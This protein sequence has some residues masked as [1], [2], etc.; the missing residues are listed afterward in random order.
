MTRIVLF[1]FILITFQS[2]LLAQMPGFTQ[3]D[4]NIGLPSNTV[5]DITQDE[6]GFIWMATD[7]GLSRFDGLSFKNFTIADGLP[8][9]EI[10]H[11]FQDSKKRIWLSGFNGKLGY[12]QKQKFY[13][14]E[15]S[16][17][18]NE[19]KFNIFISDIF[20]DSKNNI[21]FFESFN[22][23][24]KLDTNNQVSTYNFKNTPQLNNSKQYNIAEDIHGEI[25]ILKSITHKSNLSEF[26][27][28][29]ISK[30]NWENL[31][32]DSFDASV[33]IKLRTKKSEK[34]KNVDSV[35]MKILNEILKIYSYKSKSNLLYRT[36]SYNDSFII[37]NLDNGALLINP[38]NSALT[39]K[40]LPLTR[41]TVAFVDS[42]KNIWIGTQS[43]GVF[44][45]PNLNVHGIQ[46]ED[47][48]Q[49][50]LHTVSLFQNKLVIGNGQ[51]EIFILDKKTLQTIKT[52]LIDKK[53][54]R[55]RHLN[56]IN[57]IL[58][59]LS[60]LSIHQLNS[61]F[62]LERFKNMYDTDFKKTRLQN[63]KDLSIS[64]DY[65][66]TAN[67]NGVA[68]I[69]KKNK[70]PQKIW[71]KRSSAIC[72]DEKENLWIGTTTGLFY[73]SKGITNKFNLN[74]QFNNSIIYALKHSQ[75]GL[76]I[77][78]NSYGLGILKNDKFTTI[79]INDGL[80]SNYI[81]S[82]YVDP[83]N[84][85]W[86]STNFGLNCVELD[87]KNQI[88][89]IK[90]YTTSDGLYSNDVRA[91]YID[92]NKV[93]VATSKGLNIIDLNNELTKLHLQLL[94]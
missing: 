73:E 23:I 27:S 43:D 38:K 48:T 90:S 72:V 45:F 19:L 59:I 34:L 84:N 56:V 21:W 28:S 47:K 75:N 24:K 89:S 71:N 40:I 32:F 6:N 46:F 33:L 88:I 65:I 3:F 57:N 80:L 37:T 53:P 55:I 41:T 61:N 92:E 31:N 15:N 54:K 93:Y 14:S 87:D 12:I 86:L 36:F 50:D 30:L 70:T 16:K 4:S 67:A 22:N 52:F 69:D 1:F 83:K 7:Y 62:E 74:K 79:S 85:I 13:N 5:Y 11:F 51:S 17:L 9:N 76:L 78:S 81:K 49:N 26:F 68:K 10:L 25:K 2:S 64:E 18:L 42:E 20:E 39:K 66:Y 58:S 29:S 91:S 35:S 94:K 63:F 60:D 44:L 77:G 82:I 8:D